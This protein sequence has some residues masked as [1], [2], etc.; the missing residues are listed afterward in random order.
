MDWV[1]NY[2]ESIIDSL[3]NMDVGTLQPYDHFIFH[4][5]FAREFVT[6]MGEVVDEKERQG[7]PVK[8]L[9]DGL[10]LPAALPSQLYFLLLDLKASNAGRGERERLANFYF[11]MI[12]TK[13]KDDVYHFRSHILRTK[14]EVRGLL[15]EIKLH[16][17]NPDIA[18]LLAQTYNAMYNLGAG[19][20]LDFYMD[21]AVENEGAYDVS[22]IFGPDHILLIKRARGFRPVEVWPMS[23][24]FVADE[25]V[26][27]TVY[28][29]VKYRCD[30]ISI[31]SVYEGDTINGLVKFAVEVDGKFVYSTDELKKLREGLERASVEQWKCL[32]NLDFETQK[33]KGLEIR[34]YG[35][36]GVFDRLD[37]DWR[38]TK[39]MLNAIKGRGFAVDLWKQPDDVAKRR[40]YW[41]GILDPRLDVYP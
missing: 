13:L 37:M 16:D 12:R 9:A 7:V 18:R 4:P 32:K 10:Q 41:R 11:D 17:A 35:M 27:Y 2:S 34:L 3:G 6:R 29:G 20:Y 21:Y 25:I 22:D 8:E 36:K 26:L 39:E 14:S 15:R 28:T 33:R 19:L 40:E 24:D 23:K 31:H 5:L 38:P 1:D 30:G